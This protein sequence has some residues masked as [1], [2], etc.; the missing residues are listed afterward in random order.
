M[1]LFLLTLFIYSHLYNRTKY[2]NPTRHLSAGTTNRTIFRLNPRSL[3]TEGL[4]GSFSQRFSWTLVMPPPIRSPVRCGPNS[5]APNRPSVITT[6]QQTFTFFALRFK[7]FPSLIFLASCVPRLHVSVFFADFV[8]LFSA[9]LPLR[10]HWHFC[11][12][13]ARVRVGF[14]LAVV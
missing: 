13:P 14:Y 3:T 6:D 2:M 5:T 8:Q 10:F 1:V 9:A 4:G 12:Q 11:L 7:L